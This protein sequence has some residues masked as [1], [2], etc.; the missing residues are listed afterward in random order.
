MLI[1][2]S[3]ILG[4][5][6]VFII[7]HFENTVVT[8]TMDY[9]D[10]KYERAV[11]FGSY[12]NATF[13]SRRAILLFLSHTPLVSAKYGLAFD[14]SEID[15]ILNIMETHI[16]VIF[17]TT[18]LYFADTHRPLSAPT[19]TPTTLLTQ[20]RTIA[21]YGILLILGWLLLYL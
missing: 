2:I 19:P 8:D 20:I 1:A 21:K 4:G 16:N 15:S 10:A 9:V 5:A 11:E 17:L 18:S 14:T 6:V 3:I 12:L 13:V 7:G